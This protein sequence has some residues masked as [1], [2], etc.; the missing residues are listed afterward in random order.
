MRRQ[1]RLEGA[2]GATLRP[3]QKALRPGA[4]LVV[5]FIPVQLGAGCGVGDGLDPCDGFGQQHQ[6]VSGDAIVGV[7]QIT[8]FDLEGVLPVRQHGVTEGFVLDRAVGV[9]HTGARRQMNL[10][11]AVARAL[12]QNVG[13]VAAGLDA[14]QAQQGYHMV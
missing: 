2:Q 13:T 5:A 11:P 14:R 6:D 1:H 12:E 4:Q 8:G 10:A 9:E 7:H 3:D